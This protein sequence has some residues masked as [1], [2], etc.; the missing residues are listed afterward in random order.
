MFGS[1]VLSADF[2][3][4][5]LKHAN[6]G[7]DLYGELVDVTP[8]DQCLCS[9]GVPQAISEKWGQTTFKRAS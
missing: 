5:L 1:I 6:T 8:A 9:V 4:E 7:A 2:A 3:I